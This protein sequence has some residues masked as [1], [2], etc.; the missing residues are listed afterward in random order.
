MAVALAQDL[1]P[2]L[3]RASAPP[4]VL[5]LGPLGDAARRPE[6]SGAHR[7]VAVPGP[8][9]VRQLW[10]QAI[11]SPG[12]VGLRVHFTDFAVGA[13]RV[14]VHAGRRHQPQVFGPY[15][16]RGIHGDGEFWSDVLLG[17]T[18]V[19]EYEPQ[20]S[21]T[22]RI[23]EISHLWDRSI[24]GPNPLTLAGVRKVHLPP[25]AGGLDQ[26]LAEQFRATRRFTVVSDPRQADAVWTE[27]LGTLDLVAAGAGYPIW[28]TPLPSQKPSS[29]AA[30]R[31][32]RQIAGQVNKP[33]SPP[34]NR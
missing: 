14:W 1:P 5:E 26:Y 21:G 33:P 11:R 28:S 9:G 3:R 6:A 8:S 27:G 30:R 2:S 13:G 22:F 4:P 25:L 34:S 23:A 18:V 32:A 24:L 20:A 17:E 15:T 31:L 7:Q 12:A 16:G 19:I 29:R 10:R